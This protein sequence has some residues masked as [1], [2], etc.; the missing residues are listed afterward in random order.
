MPLLTLFSQSTTTTGDLTLSRTVSVV[1]TQ[2]YSLSFWFDPSNVTNNN[3]TPQMQIGILTNDGL[4]TISSM[5]LPLNCTVGRYTLPNWKCPANYVPSSDSMTNTVLTGF[6]LGT[7]G[8]AGATDVEYTGTGI[9]ATTSLEWRSSPIS[10]TPGQ[11]YTP[12]FWCTPSV[13]SH[14][15]MDIR[16]INTSNSAVLFDTN[17]TG[18][19]AG[20]ADGRYA[21]PSFT[22]PAGVTSIWVDFFCWNGQSGG[23]IVNNGSKWKMS[24]PMLE[25]SNSAS[26]YY[27]SSQ[28]PQVQIYG[29]LL[30]TATLTSGTTFKISQPMFQ[31]V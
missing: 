15:G 30:S 5:N 19:T 2:T 10:V 21:A 11:V 16:I 4:T 9:N 7:G 12:S 17:L 14:G 24:Q 26:G 6:S 27:L 18:F 20:G 23:F 29:K 8:P 22:V 25:L 1:P 31:M 28:I 13:V 3:V